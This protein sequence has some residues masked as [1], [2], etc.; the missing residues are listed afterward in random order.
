MT[1]AGKLVD[2]GINIQR[3]A[4]VDAASQPAGQDAAVAFFDRDMAA[5]IARMPTEMRRQTREIIMKIQEE[6]RAAQITAVGAE[7]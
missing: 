7:K 4:A 5:I 1:A 2:L 6:Q 3:R